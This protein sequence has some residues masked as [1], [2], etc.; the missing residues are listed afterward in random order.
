MMVSNHFDVRWVDGYSAVSDVPS[1]LAAMIEKLA[2]DLPS[3]HDRIEL[4]VRE[5][6]RPDGTTAWV[7]L[8]RFVVAVSSA[9]RPLGFLHAAV[10]P[11]SYR[12]DLDGWRTLVARRYGAHPEERIRTLYE[13][14]AESTKDIGRDRLHALAI[15]PE[16]VRELLAPLEDDE[17]PLPPGLPRAHVRPPSRPPKGSYP[18]AASAS[19]IASASAAPGP[20]ARPSA[21]LLPISMQVVN[22][23]EAP[24]EPKT[25]EMPSMS[26]D[27]G[28]DVTQPMSAPSVAAS[29]LSGE[30]PQ[31]R[32]REE[33]GQRA[34]WVAPAVLGTVVILL[35]AVG[36]LAHRHLVLV[37]EHEELKDELL[38]GSPDRDA[39]KRDLT[40]MARLR[41]ELDALRIAQKH[42]SEQIEMA[43]QECKASLN[44]A[45]GL[46]REIAD[47]LDRLQETARVSAIELADC[48]SNLAKARANL[49]GSTS[50]SDAERDYRDEELRARDLEA[51]NETLRG[52]VSEREKQLSLFPKCLQ[53]A[54]SGEQPPQRECQ[55][56]TRD[57]VSDRAAS[58]PDECRGGDRHL[59]SSCTDAGRDAIDRAPGDRG[60]RFARG[61]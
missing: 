22:L 48:K 56:I 61:L 27:L 58:V 59:R 52:K 44:D 9:P 13:E 4:A 25:E 10:L 36:W 12:V 14:L 37:K 43:L 32:L 20:K 55:R 21:P 45:R 7:G 51:E 39:W 15:R 54:R 18:R 35:G 3:S 38:K 11:T 60:V 23:P 1:S 50:K 34:W 30:H 33:R 46:A 19:G 47:K 17:A 6:R 26:M 57:Q 53:S 28:N 31:H 8:L 42:C 29:P 2:A 41:S 24:A 16:D 5:V 49:D 40:E